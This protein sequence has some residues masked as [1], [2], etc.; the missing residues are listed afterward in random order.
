MADSPKP[1]RFIVIEGCATPSHIH[2]GKE[3]GFA[4]YW[5]GTWWAGKDHEPSGMC[6]EYL[7]RYELVE[8]IPNPD[9]QQGEREVTPIGS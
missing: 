7:H 9:Y 2:K 6:V 5:N 1:H 8:S 4:P 3:H